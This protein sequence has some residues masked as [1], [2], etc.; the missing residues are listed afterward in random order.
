MYAYWLI[1]LIGLFI[2]WQLRMIFKYN[3]GYSAVRVDVNNSRLVIDNK[4]IRFKDIKTIRIVPDEKQP[5]SIEKGLSK[6]ASYIYLSTI[7]IYLNNG[8]M[9]P[10]KC[11]SKAIIKNLITNAEHLPQLIYNEDD[12]EEKGLPPLV[13][14]LIFIIILYVIVFAMTSHPH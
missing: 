8:T 1:L 7:E 4:S 5:S 6:G 14:G 9:M 2:A 10:V 13:V 3:I 11:N 12:L